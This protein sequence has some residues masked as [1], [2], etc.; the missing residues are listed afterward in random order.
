MYDHLIM[1]YCFYGHFLWFIYGLF[2]AFIWTGQYRVD[3]KALGE[4]GEK[5]DKD[6]IKHHKVLEHYIPIVLNLFHSLMWGTVEYL[7]H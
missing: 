4:E 2:Y 7:S 5:W 6:I 1:Y 3:R